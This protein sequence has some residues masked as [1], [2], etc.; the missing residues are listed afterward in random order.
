VKALLLLT[1]GLAAGCAIAM[2]PPKTEVEGL[3]VSLFDTEGR[4]AGTVTLA[5]D[6]NQVLLFIFDTRGLPPGRHAVH[7]H[8]IGNCTR[9]DFL[10]AGPHLD[11]GR[12]QHGKQNPAGPHTGDL[13]DIVVNEAG[14][15]H[16]TLRLAPLD[17][18]LDVGAITGGD[19]S[20]IV[21][22]AD[23]DDQR[24]DPSGNSGARIACG[25]LM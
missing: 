2:G 4:R 13:D 17:G 20:A 1:L 21:I 18:R 19:G 24:T 25:I 12:H 9:P 16:D 23:P 8:A 22:H 6:G 10:S 14:I 5:E 3:V 11:Q 15:S 7:L